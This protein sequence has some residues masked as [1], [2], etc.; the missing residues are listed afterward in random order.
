MMISLARLIC[1]VASLQQI[2][3]LDRHTFAA[4]KAVG[5]KYQLQVGDGHQR[6]VEYHHH[7]EQVDKVMGV[8]TSLN[9]RR[10]ISSFL[11]SPISAT[12]IYQRLDNKSVLSSQQHR[13]DVYVPMR[14]PRGGG[15]IQ[16]TMKASHADIMTT[17]F[18]NNTPF[19]QYNAAIGI[20][21][22]LGM[23]LSLLTGKQIHLDLLGTGAF[24]LASSFVLFNAGGGLLASAEVPLRIQASSAA[25]ILW[26]VK[27]ASFLF[28]RACVVKSDAR[29]DSML[30]TTSGIVT[31]WIFS[32]LWGVIASL[33]H[34]LGLTTSSSP[35]GNNLAMLIGTMIYTVGFLMETVAD[36]QKWMYKQQNPGQF[37]NVGLWSVSQ[38]PNFFGNLLVWFGIFVINLPALAEPFS[39]AL[40]SIGGEGTSSLL[41]W[42]ASVLANTFTSLWSC[43]RAAVACLSP[44]F[45]WVLF[46]GQAEGNIGSG[47]EQSLLRYGK[48]PEFIEYVRTVPLIVP[49]LQLGGKK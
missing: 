20:V 5:S 14:V 26:S 34:S 2:F 31:F 6:Q 27:L 39:F 36:Y 21:N 41:T 43:R 9:K 30:S 28:Y 15:G 48:D 3:A 45:L 13:R 25:V 17:S 19:L 35:S 22:I 1:I 7:H 47:V 23:L 33:P 49:D 29:L 32:L 10:A 4:Y 38:H 46:T 24:A 11:L 42:I 16:T 44:A 40:P 12:S 18:F 8:M 37:C